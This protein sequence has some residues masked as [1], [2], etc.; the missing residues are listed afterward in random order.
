MS[1][2]V[3]RLAAVP[4]TRRGR[5]APD[6]LEF[7]SAGG[8]QESDAALLRVLTTASGGADGGGGKVIGQP[9]LWLS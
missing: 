8:T 7:R 4:E 3:V 2:E 6:D 1:G 5:P 9:P